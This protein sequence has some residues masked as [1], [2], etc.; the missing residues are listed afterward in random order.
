MLTAIDLSPILLHI[1]S[2]EFVNHKPLQGA[3]I[4]RRTVSTLDLVVLYTE[5]HLTMREIGRV[6]GMSGPGV[7]KRLHK[8]GITGQDGERVIRSCGYCGVE[9]NRPRSTG[10]RK[11]QVYCCAE[12]YY[13]ARENPQFREWRQ[14]SRLARALVAQH[15]PLSPIEIVH[16][17]DG[18]QRH[19]DLA[20]LAVYANQADHIAV[21]HGRMIDPI[22]DGEKC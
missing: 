4:M 11:N 3:K 2:V 17:K 1:Y 19:N 9:V 22:W 20:N 21:H 5:K 8:A 13:A 10:L 18:D 6:V 12:H 16:H 14:G 7:M 15:Y